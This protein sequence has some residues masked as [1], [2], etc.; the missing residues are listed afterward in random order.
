MVE[1]E[2]AHEAASNPAAAIALEVIVPNAPVIVL[3]KLQSL[4]AELNGDPDFLPNRPLGAKVQTGVAIGVRKILDLLGRDNP[5]E[6]HEARE[7]L[8]Q[9][10]E[11]TWPLDDVMALMNP[12]AIAGW[13][14]PEATED[15]MAQRR[16]AAADVFS[17]ERKARLSDIEG[18]L[19]ELRGLRNVVLG[20]QKHW[21]IAPRKDMGLGKAV[22]KEQVWYHAQQEALF[23]QVTDAKWKLKTAKEEQNVDLIT[24]LESKI[25]ALQKEA[26][27]AKSYEAVLSAFGKESPQSRW[28]IGAAIDALNESRD[29]LK[30][31]R[32]ESPNGGL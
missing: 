4:Y 5:S 9:S 22:A 25:T 7:D 2:P 24:P 8:C 11:A 27:R 3:A 6:V 32:I 19:K 20:L 10:I 29:I 31:D 14:S 30:T 21:V 26:A 18:C 12:E 13:G 17:S 23:I 1:L 16:G 28:P 15:W